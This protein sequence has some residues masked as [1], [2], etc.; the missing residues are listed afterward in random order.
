[1]KAEQELGRGGRVYLVKVQD[2]PI[3][4]QLV[5][6]WNAGIETAVFAKSVEPRQFLII[7][8]H[9]ADVKKGVEA[10]KKTKFAGGLITVRNPPHFC[11]TWE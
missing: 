10:L 4:E 11:F 7:F 2:P 9:D 5:K 8:K 1:L 6:S 3:T